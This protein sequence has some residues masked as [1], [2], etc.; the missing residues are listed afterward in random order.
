MKRRVREEGARVGRTP[1]TKIERS[2]AGCGVRTA[3]GTVEKSRGGEGEE[4]VRGGRVPHT[5]IKRSEGGER[6]MEES[7]SWPCPVNNLSNPR[8]LTCTVNH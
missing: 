7:R 1:S 4:G 8:N 3:A 2:E 5:E 6:Q